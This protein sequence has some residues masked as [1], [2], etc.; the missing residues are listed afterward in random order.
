MSSKTRLTGL[1]CLF[2]SLLSLFSRHI[3]LQLKMSSS[4]SPYSPLHHKPASPET[5][6]PGH[7]PQQHSHSTATQA[8]DNFVDLDDDD[9][10]FDALWNTDSLLNDDFNPLVLPPLNP[11]HNYHQLESPSIDDAHFQFFDSLPRLPSPHYR[12]PA[13]GIS[14]EEDPIP[15]NQQARR[16]T[17]NTSQYQ[18]DGGSESPDPFA[19]Y[20]E[21]SPPPANMPPRPANN[22]AQSSAIVDLTASSPEQAARE[23]APTRKRKQPGAQT[24]K[25]APLTRPANSRTG[26]TRPVSSSS[27]DA[28]QEGLDK[29]ELVDL[30]AVE[31]DAQYSEFRSQE[32]AARAKAQ[33]DLLRD[34]NVAEANKPVKLAEFQ[35]II[36]MDNPTDLTVTHCGMYC[37]FICIK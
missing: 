22:T 14:S 30:S 32:E 37:I 27:V 12:S 21:L 19:A 9:D 8:R 35:C 6:N 26:D 33:A 31:G 16:H 15:S 11:N 2:V 24:A 1:V 3:L 13:T 18:I 5:R 23:M 20:L 17:S 4:A 36:C 7:Q 28:K 10:D 29:V 25:P 34:Q